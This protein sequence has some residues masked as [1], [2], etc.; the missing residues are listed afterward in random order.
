M[1]MG[2]PLFK[3]INPGA[4]GYIDVAGKQRHAN[5]SQ[6]ALWQETAGV[7]L[8]SQ[9]ILLDDLITT[10]RYRFRSDNPH[11]EALV[12]F[13][14]HITNTRTYDNFAL[15]VLAEP[16]LW[17]W[18]KRTQRQNEAIKPVDRNNDA[19]KALGYGLVGQYGIHIQRHLRSRTRNR[20]Y[21][22]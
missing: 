11:H 22:I 9:Y 19:M 8:H 16:Y 21:F 10:L 2:N 17:K 15:D 14:S 3:R 18:P 13:N 4:A 20:S 6:V 12:Y 5:K 7:T 1:A